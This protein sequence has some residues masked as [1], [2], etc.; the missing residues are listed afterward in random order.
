MPR[1]P[2]QLGFVSDK[3]RG[4]GLVGRLERVRDTSAH[5]PELEE[6]EQ[7]GDQPEATHQT[8]TDLG[9]IEGCSFFLS[10]KKMLTLDSE[11]A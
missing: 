3:W 4:L 11:Q 9:A 7:H 6:L 1:Q 2:T 10:N 8:G 5:G